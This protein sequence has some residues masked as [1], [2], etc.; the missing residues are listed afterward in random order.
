M[1]RERP[2]DLGAFWMPF[3]PNRDFKSQPRMLA[4]AEGMYFY[5]E[6]G[7]ALTTR[8]RTNNSSPGR[9]GARQRS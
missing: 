4:R 2:N 9:T 6:D 1:S 7:R 3:T 8:T 5:D